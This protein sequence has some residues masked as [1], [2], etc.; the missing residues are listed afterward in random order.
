MLYDCSKLAERERGLTAAVEA[1]QRGD[2]VVFP[3]DT[4]YGLGC[5]AFKSWSVGT[6]LR[7]KGRGREM[8]TPVMVASRQMLD[9][10]VYGLPQAARDLVEAFWPGPL[11][12]LVEHAPSLDWDLGET[13]GVIQV[14]MPL[15]PVAL[16]LIREVGPMAVSSAN[17]KDSAPAH[18]AEEA[19][20]QFGYEVGVYLEAGP[21]EQHLASTIVDCTTPTP[22]VLRV[23]ALSLLELR[24]ISP[25][26]VE[27]LA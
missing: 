23:G 25:G 21:A 4:V 7:A 8:P 20:E 24:E 18:T 9:G 5:D 26:I 3:T 14:R 19:K 10:L 17:K 2:L 11:T 13:D 22:K 6:L 12:V 27:E 1:A 15:H 16:D